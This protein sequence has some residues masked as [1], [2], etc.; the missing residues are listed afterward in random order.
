MQAMELITNHWVPMDVEDALE[1]VGP[2]W[3]HPSLRSYAVGRLSTA[4]D[5]DLLLYLLQ[6]VQALKYETFSKERKR[7]SSSTSFQDLC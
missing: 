6:L 7:Q 2:N 4:S 3:R 1:L 5:E